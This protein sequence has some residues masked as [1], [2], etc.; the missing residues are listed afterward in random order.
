MK[1]TVRMSWLLVL[2]FTSVSLY[3][4]SFNVTYPFTNVTASSGLTDPTPVPT[5]TGITFGSFTS[6]GASANPNAGGRFSFTAWSIGATNGD[7]ATFTGGSN[8]GQYFQVTLT[9][10]ANFQLDLTSLTFKVQRSATGPRQ[11]VVRSSVDGF[12]ANLPASIN[13]GN[14]NLLIAP[15][16]VFQLKDASA[17]TAE[18]GSTVDLSSFTG[19][20]GAIS[21][22]FYIFN[23]EASGGSFSVDDVNFIGATSAATGTPGL[24]VDQTSFNFPATAISTSAT[25]LTYTVQGNNLIDPVFIS[26][27]APFAVS[28]DNV[29]FTTSLTVPAVDVATP[30]TIYV[31]FSPVTPGSFSGAVRN[32]STNAAT[33]NIIVN[34]DA[35][36][37]TNLTFN[38]DACTSAG[39]P[40]SGFLSYSVTGAQ[41]W[42]C[43]NF[44]NNGTHGVD[45][46][47]F[48]GGALANEDWLISPNLAIGGTNIP[49]LSFYSR[50]EFSGPSLQLLVSTNYSGS[51]NPNLATW[52]TL[53]AN[54]PTVGSNTWTLSDNISLAA[55]KSSPTVY[56]AFKYTSSPALGAARWTLD[57]VKVTDQST[58]FSVT[59]GAL[60]FGE[61]SV[62]AHSPGQNISLQS[63]GFGDITVT[64]PAGF[65]VSLNN[66]TFSNSIIVPDATASAG[67]TVYARYS[68]AVK[69]LKS[70]GTVSFAGTGL[71]QSSVTLTGSSYPKSETFDVACYN[72]SFFGSN[73]TNNPTQ[74]KIDL[75]VANI[76]TVVQRLNMDVIGVEE[77]SNDAAFATLMSNLPGYSSTI[78]PRYSYSFDGPDP[79]FPPQKVGFIY[80]TS[81]TTLVD[82]R[83]MFEKL[84]D[85]VRAGNLSLLPNYPGVPDAGVPGDQPAFH[86]WSSGR[87][88]YLATFDVNING[89]TRRI[90]VIDIHAKSGGD[91]DSYNRRV[92]DAQ[93]LK[94]SLDAFYPNDNIIIVGDYNDRL[95]SSIYTG[96]T[97]SSYAPFVN[98][99][100]N[101]TALTY[102]L[103]A[104]GS[105]SF[106]GDVGMIDQI[107]VSN[108]LQSDLIPNS[109]AIED[110]RTYIS[111]Y[112]ATTAS[113]HLPVFSRL[114]LQAALPVTLVNFT[115]TRKDTKVLVNW[116]TATEQHNDY[117]IVERSGDGRNFVP[118]AKVKAKGNS[119]RLVN[120]EL[121]D[122]LPLAGTNYYRL[123]QV[124]VD[125]KFT[126]SPIAVVKMNGQDA[127]IY[128]YPNPVTTFAR[129]N[130]APNAKFAARIA[131]S[132]GSLI[133]SLKGDVNQI[134]AAINSALPR[135]TSGLYILTLQNDT[136]QQTIKMVKQ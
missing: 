21:F 64:A 122:S 57:D 125:G 96:T 29:T 45:M 33:Q 53:N 100:A 31:Q 2:L 135:M 19:L 56:I 61:T 14:A 111:N 28:T 65:E 47:G 98:D 105:T 127:T 54:F 91:V 60:D 93:V 6:T 103:D 25:S 89:V 101:Y 34:G 3:S 24:I 99:N 73:S 123:K 120:Y 20:T 78:S 86:F 11:F 58:L 83:V 42:A 113:D 48:S 80:N 35:V 115:A 132:Q 1:R 38:F 66:V 40:G 23:S 59:P 102:A 39:L 62:G 17:S 68:P 119:N 9:P 50:A 87:L 18:V 41:K 37:P 117:F 85:D 12:T 70:T 32:S 118:I 104:A 124:D 5:A 82:S 109:T 121:T 134:N 84:F 133:L 55:Y 30:K 97:V 75:Q 112:N 4:Q 130:A 13:P 52:T 67:T 74:A 16:N 81:T 88:P 79:N 51:G 92:Y 94:D 95:V 126:Y 36:D 8:A 136:G 26:T 77:V 129:I 7:D 10:Q 46:N 90:R 44:G 76:T 107:I 114:S 71:T 106:P 69:E 72:L 27:A 108:E 43:S 49:V 131:T 15:T 63:I 110:P 128:L 116:T 22:R